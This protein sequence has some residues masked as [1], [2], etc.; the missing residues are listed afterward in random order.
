MKMPHFSTAVY[1]NRVAGLTLNGAS[2]PPGVYNAATSAPYLAGAGS[3]L[4]VGPV[5]APQISLTTPGLTNL[6]ASFTS[7]NGVNFVLQTATNLAPP[8]PWLD[9]Q[10]NLGTGGGQSFTN[11]IDA[12]PQKFFRVRAY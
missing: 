1:T 9:A 7:Q 5:I 10:T 3:L 12:Q 11:L 2:Q 4:Y 6:I 8:V